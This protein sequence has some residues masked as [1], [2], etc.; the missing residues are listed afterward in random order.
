MKLAEQIETTRPKSPSRVQVC[1]ETLEL[2]AGRH[3]L[4]VKFAAPTVYEQRQESFLRQP[5]L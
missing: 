5:P 3:V 4:E 2:G 1:S